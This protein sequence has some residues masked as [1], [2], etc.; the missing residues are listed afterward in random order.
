MGE[1]LPDPPKPVT[2]GTLS[3]ETPGEMANADWVEPIAAVICGAMLCV[4]ILT[5]LFAIVLGLNFRWQP[6]PPSQANVALLG[7]VLGV[8]NLLLW[9]ALPLC[10]LMLSRF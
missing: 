6:R 2:V 4:P 1:D 9:V 7:I 5:G 3:Y 8:M 10:L